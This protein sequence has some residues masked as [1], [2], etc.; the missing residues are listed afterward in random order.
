MTERRL[1]A[2][3]AADGHVLTP[4]DLPPFLYETRQQMNRG[5]QASADIISGVA[6]DVPAADSS[7]RRQP[8]KKV[9]SSPGFW[10][11]HHATTKSPEKTPDGPIVKTRTIHVFVAYVRGT[12]R[13]GIADR[14]EG[15]TNEAP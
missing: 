15:G 12:L 3:S 5:M 1:D 4:N 11:P 8:R 13:S 14:D 7:S 2:T 6:L 9:L 10:M